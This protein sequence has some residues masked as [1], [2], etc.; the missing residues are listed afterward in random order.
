[1]RALG[2]IERSAN[3]ARG[4]AMNERRTYRVAA[5]GEAP[6]R[7]GQVAYALVLLEF[8]ALALTAS[9]AATAQTAR[10]SEII[11]RA[12]ALKPDLA[13]GAG[14]YRTHCSSCHGWAGLGD[15]KAVVPAI[16]G[17]VSSYLVKQL[18]DVAEGDRDIPEMHRT[19]SRI[20]FTRPQALRDVTAYVHSLPANSSPQRGDGKQLTLGEKVYAASCRQCHGNKGEG[21]EKSYV[22][23]LRGLDYAYLLSEMR[24]LAVGHRY[25][26]D[27]DVI[28]M[29]EALS[30]DQ[31]SAVAD[32]M[33]RLPVPPERTTVKVMVSAPS[34]A[35]M[36]SQ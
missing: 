6:K 12:M 29:L 10:V 35:S 31:L 1:M 11:E 2:K 20:E 13:A 4:R 5:Q 34:Q 19:V 33:S 9:H 14:L 28:E 30:L 16:A 21:D 32:Y 7:C 36:E 3:P 17:Q 26:V 25:S 18:A 27:V 8:T 23:A 15:P 22:P 24:G